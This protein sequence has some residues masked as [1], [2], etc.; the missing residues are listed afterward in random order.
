MLKR[1]ITELG[2]HYIVFEDTRAAYNIYPEDF[3][4][5]WFIDELGQRWVK[6]RQ[7]GCDCVHPASR[8]V[9]VVYHPKP[10]PTDWPQLEV[11]DD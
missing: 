5:K 3:K 7:D 2:I 9:Q 10:V 11:A 6:Y 1:E 8:V 4:A